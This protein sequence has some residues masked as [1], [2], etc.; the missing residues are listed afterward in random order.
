[1]RTCLNYFHRKI[2][3][4]AVG[5]KG[6]KESAMKQAIAEAKLWEM[7]F[8]AIEKSRQEYRESSRKLVAENDQLQNA[9]SQ[10]S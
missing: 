7:R 6:D 3:A 5:A 10:V 2:T 8:Q 1:M 9:I 4:A